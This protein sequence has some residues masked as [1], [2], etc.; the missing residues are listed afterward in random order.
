MYQT[1]L[2]DLDGTLLD[3]FGL[4]LA[5]FHHTRDV[6]FGDRLEDDFYL[7]GIGTTLRDQLGKM[8]RSADELDAMIE[9][10][11]THNLASHD[12]HVRAYDGATE[13]VRALEAANV[14]LAIVTGKMRAGA[15]MGL[16]FLAIEDAFGSIV[17]GD[18]VKLGKPHPE[19]VHRA[20]EE[21]GV[22]AESAVFVGD[23][24]HDMDAGSAAGVA[25]ALAAYGPFGP[26]LKTKVPPTHSIQSLAELL[27]LCASA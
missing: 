22:S 18:D 12:S 5:S 4:I 7:A 24:V 16:R 25:T 6:H 17:C 10:Y 9:T 20:L 1:V 8:A 21:L 15:R 2:F 27:P 19:P 13:T 23:S 3:S 11:K 26:S 14:K